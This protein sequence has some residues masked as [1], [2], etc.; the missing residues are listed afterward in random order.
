[1]GSIKENIVNSMNSAFTLMEVVIIITVMSFGAE[2]KLYKLLDNK[3]NNNN[4]LQD[5][6]RPRLAALSAPVETNELSET[7]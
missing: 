1:M 6:F 5:Y 3:R 4:N 7:D 2:K